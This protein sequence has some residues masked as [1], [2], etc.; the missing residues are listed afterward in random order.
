MEL[1]TN[2]YELSNKI[3]SEI[4][5]SNIGEEVSMGNMRQ[6]YQHEP[7]SPFIEDRSLVWGAAFRQYAPMESLERL[8]MNT[9]E[10]AEEGYS[11]W[12]DPQIKWA[13]LQG[14]EYRFMSSRSSAETMM[15][16]EDYKSDIYDME[17]L[18]NSGSNI[19]AS[20]AAGFT[21]PALLL[22]WAP[23]SV[24]A[25]ASWF[26]RFLGGALYTGTIM[27]PEEFLIGSQ[28]YNKDIGYVWCCI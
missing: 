17:V 15:R 7:W 13:G 14:H 23:K 20:L 22:G 5:A 1:T 28:N 24:M 18:N 2:F 27:A 4:D 19:T 21:S 26:K 10:P 25:S 9:T 6:L 3:N 8:F 16:I 11:V 12:D